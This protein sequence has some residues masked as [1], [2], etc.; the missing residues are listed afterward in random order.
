MLEPGW[1]PPRVPPGHRPRKDNTQVRRKVGSRVAVV[2]G[3]LV[4]ALGAPVS[5][6]AGSLVAGESCAGAATGPTVAVVVDFGDVGGRG[7]PPGGVVTALRAV[8]QR[9]HGTR[10]AQECG[11]HVR[12]RARVR[13][14]RSTAI[15]PTAVGRRRANGSTCTG[16][17][18]RRRRARDSWSYSLT[19][20]AHEDPR[21]GD[22][23]LAIRRGRR[24]SERSAAARASRTTTP[25]ADRRPT[26]T[27]RTPRPLPSQV[28]PRNRT[29]P[30]SPAS[31]DGDDDSGCVGARRCRR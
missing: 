17:T 8:V 3:A 29:L 11:P 27:R 12:A 18:G 4:V 5:V 26:R 6:T 24:Q 21:R 7:T 28:P 13:F 10:R 1:H 23:R 16:R 9:L 19:G 2:I 20:A 15:R 14:A 31:S 25:R 22:R 30:A